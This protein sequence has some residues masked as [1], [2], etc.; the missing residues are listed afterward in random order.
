MLELDAE[1]MSKSLGNVVTLRN[2]LDTWG[3]EALLVFH[4]TGNWSK[5]VDFSDEVM[6]AAAAR[7]EGLRNVFRSPERTCCRRGVARFAAALD[8]DFSTPE[9]L[10]VMHEWR[11]HE[12]LLGRSTSSGSSSLAEDG[13]APGGGARSQWSGAGACPHTTST[14]RT[15]CGQRDHQRAGKSGTIADSFGSCGGD[16]AQPTSSTAGKAVREP[17]VARQALRLCVTERAATKSASWG[18]PGR[19]QVKPERDLTEQSGTRDHQGVVAGCEP[20]PYADAHGLA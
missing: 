11:D 18:T 15:A 19:P 4:L 14:R 2:V 7:A 17:S 5:P 3:R 1:K 6:D 8:D 20:Y 13:R 12:L 10:A 16:D 9:A